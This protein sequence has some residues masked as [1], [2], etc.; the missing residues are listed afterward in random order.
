MLGSINDIQFLKLHCRPSSHAFHP[1]QA[2]AD[3]VNNAQSLEGV[4]PYHSHHLDQSGIVTLANA[5]RQHTALQKF[6]WLHKVSPRVAP[7]HYFLDPVIQ[8]LP[9]CPHLQTVSIA[10]NWA[11]ADAVRNLLHS[12]PTATQF[13]LILTIE[14]WLVVADE[15]QRGRSNPKYLALAMVPCASSDEATEAAKVMAGAIRQDRNLERLQLR[16][17]NGFTDEAGVALAGALTVNKTLR[18]VVLAN[19]LRSDHQVQNKATVGVQAYEAF[20]AMLR[21]NTSLTLQLPPFNTAGGDRRVLESHNQMCIE[22]HLNKA[23]RGE[24]LSSSQKTRAAW[25]DALQKLNAI[26]VTQPYYSTPAFQVSCLFSLLRLN[27]A[28]CMLQPNDT[29]NSGL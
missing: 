4:A 3:A 29:S 26:Y 15:I 5:L 6:N 19:V 18:K 11:S 1:F 14:H 23:G 10:T 22:A 9:A 25:V 28:V 2:I 12:P 21:V 24:L 16:M 17:E 20:S 13:Q 8:A 7:Q 27:P